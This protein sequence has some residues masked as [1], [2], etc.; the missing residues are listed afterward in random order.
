[1]FVRCLDWRLKWSEDYVWPP[2][3]SINTQIDQIKLLYKLLFSSDRNVDFCYYEVT[4]EY[5]IF[6]DILLSAWGFRSLVE[7]LKGSFSGNDYWR[8]GSV[9]IKVDPPRWMMNRCSDSCW[10]NGPSTFRFHTPGNTW[11]KI[12]GKFNAFGPNSSCYQTLPGCFSHI[13]ISL[14]LNF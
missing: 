9:P 11:Y 14:A 7:N 8:E 6:Y 3:Q 10:M 2:D 4:R 1:M 13:L 5:T 12:P